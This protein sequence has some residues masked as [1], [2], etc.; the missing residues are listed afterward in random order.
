MNPKTA[1]RILIAFG[2]LVAAATLAPAPAEAQSG[3]YQYY[4]VTP[5]R[6]YDTRT[7]AP[8]A[9]GTGGGIFATITDPDADNFR[10]WRARGACGI[11]TTAKAM[12]LNFSLVTPTAPAGGVI[13]ICPSP[14]PPGYPC[15]AIVTYNM[16]ETLANGGLI[17][18]G[19]VATPGTDNDIM[20][21]GSG[22]STP[23]IY[24]NYTYH[25][26]LD[27]TGYFQ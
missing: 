22:Y 5:C 20:V 18:L 23:G 25:V 3:P 27:V 15:R 8:S 21:R 19:D 12:T 2:V 14:M 11:P 6:L 10:R 13:Q 16:P 24:G 1:R 26:T 9:Q 7:G 4:A 17:P